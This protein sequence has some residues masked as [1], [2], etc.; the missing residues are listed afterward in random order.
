MSWRRSSALP[1]C[2]SRSSWRSS[3][4]ARRGGGSERRSLP[5]RDHKKGAAMLTA[6]AITTAV[7]TALSPSSWNI[8]GLVLMLIGVVLLF[9]YGMPYRVRTGGA[10][11]IIARGVDANEIKAEKFYARLGWIG[12]VLL[13]VGTLFQIVANLSPAGGLY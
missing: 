9:R 10:T 2:R 7:I 11:N 6:L 8:A 1:S 4:T 12:L 5:D 13:V 3:T